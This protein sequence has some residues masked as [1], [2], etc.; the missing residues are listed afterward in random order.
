MRVLLVTAHFRPHV[1]G[2]ERF[3]ETLAE[4]L[5]ARGHEV[6]VLCCRTRREAS[7]AEE[8]DAGYRVLRVPCSTILERRLRVPYPLPAPGPL[9]QALRR[10]LPKADVVHVQ[11]ALYATSLAALVGARRTKV[12][13]L[14]TQHVGFV[15]QGRRSLDV[16][17][18]VALSTVGRSARL[19]TRV[20][21]LN[22]EVA[23]FARRTWGLD[24]V[25]VEPVGVPRAPAID[26]ARARAELGLAPDR[27]VALFVGRNVPKKGL[28]HVLGAGDPAYEILA[29]TDSAGPAPAGVT[30][31]PFM[32][33][34][35]LHGVYAA[36]DAFVLPSVGEGIPVV[37][38]EAMSHG[39]PI[40]TT[41]G[42]GYRGSFE[43][44][45]VSD[46]RPDPAEIRRALRELATDPHRRAALSDRS[47]EV[48]A[49]RFGAD[50]FVERML[51]LYRSI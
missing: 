20:V 16:L 25:S 36:V 47:R 43:R 23:R 10:E 15:P 28:R 1:G 21:A 11:D 7:L 8:D 22:D 51:E 45:D 44:E 50:R 9:F 27:F 19:A 24:G 49:A 48:Y 40:V 4:G 42:D 13:A 34:E 37:L 18:R 41:Y 17:E 6:T 3:T 35:R 26:R 2:I 30:L 46:V 33:P 38:Q 29:V 31:L 14:L 12:P 5:V 32:S 39:L